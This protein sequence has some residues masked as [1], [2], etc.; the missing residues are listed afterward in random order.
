MFSDNF[1]YF[2]RCTV[3]FDMYKYKFCL[4]VQENLCVKASNESLE[5]FVIT[6]D[7]KLKNWK[8]QLQQRQKRKSLFASKP[9]V[10]RPFINIVIRS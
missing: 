1:H 4:L 3:L 10:N 8:A 2:E 7:S 9:F 5:Y 6:I